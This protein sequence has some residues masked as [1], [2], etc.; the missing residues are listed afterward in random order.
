MLKK[1]ALKS[2]NIAPDHSW[3]QDAPRLGRN[4]RNPILGGGGY[5][6]E[7]IADVGVGD[8]IVAR[9]AKKMNKE[10]GRKRVVKGGICIKTKEK[11]TT[12]RESSV[13]GGEPPS[14][15]KEITSNRGKLVWS[16]KNKIAGPQKKKKKGTKK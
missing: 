16:S 3:G 12:K 7:E 10:E 4:E 13:G 15:T 6:G 11:T 2:Q 5:G 14:S 9:T 8:S 1:S